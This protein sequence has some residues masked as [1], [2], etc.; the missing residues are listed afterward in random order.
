MCVLCKL[1]GN[2]IGFFAAVSEDS[3]MD[4]CLI[5]HRLSGISRMGDCCRSGYGLAGSR[6][7]GKSAGVGSAARSCNRG[8]YG[9]A[10]LDRNHSKSSGCPTRTS[11]LVENSTSPSTSKL[12]LYVPGDSN[13]TGP[14][15]ITKL[16]LRLASLIVSESDGV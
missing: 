7:D 5:R 9:H 12:I 11:K 1:A 3:R 15:V 13:F 10:C 4:G 16:L 14:I 8:V 2:V 6:S